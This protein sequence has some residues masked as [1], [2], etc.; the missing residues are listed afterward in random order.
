[1]L[2]VWAY[3]HGQVLDVTNFLEDHPGG[4]RSITKFAGKDG[5][6]E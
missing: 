5:T 3:S 2:H 4:K 6:K 1:M